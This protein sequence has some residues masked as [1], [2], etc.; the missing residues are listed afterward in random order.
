MKVGT[1]L[2]TAVTVATLAL[3]ASAQA[4]PA[5]PIPDVD[6]GSSAPESIGSPV[7]PDP[8]AAPDIPR[9][10]KMAPNG[11]S[12]L[13]NDGYMSDTYTWSGP[14][15]HG[16]S[17]RSSFLEGVCGS[18]TFDSRG[19]LVTVCVGLEGP[20]LVLADAR[21]LETLALR[22]LPPRQ[23]VA[24][25]PFQDFAG[26]GY[27]YLD[28]EDRVVAPTTTRHIMVIKVQGNDF[29]TQRDYDVSSLLAPND[30]IVSTL[31]DWSGR[32]WFVSGQGVVGSIDPHTGKPQLHKTGEVIAN[33]FSVDEDGGVYVVTDAALYRFD[34]DG[35]GAPK[36]TWREAYKNTGAQKPGQSSAGSGTTPTVMGRDLVSITDNADPI[37]IVVYRRAKTVKVARRICEEP[38][39]PKGK[40]STDQSLIG[41]HKSMIVENNYGYTG[42]LA[43]QGTPTTEPGLARVDVSSDRKAC[44]TIWKSDEIAPSVVPKLSLRSGLVYTYTNERDSSDPWYLTA[45]DF[46]TG[47]TVFKR[48]AGQSLGVNNNYAP[49][50]IAPDGSVYIGVLGG[51]VMLRNDRDPNA[52][53]PRAPRIALALKRAKDGAL[54]ASLKGEGNGLVASV[55]YRIAGKAAAK[56]SKTSPFRRTLRQATLRQGKR[57]T[58]SARVKLKDGRS[59][60]YK[61]RFRRR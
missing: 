42:P 35:D 33:S 32:I 21:T 54:R 14:L 1:T 50:T 13:H 29:Q 4:I 36:V 16:M 5:I 17:V 18:I 19:R 11:L 41:T 24:A 40:G 15:G 6:T 38:V 52:V 3:P 12:N 39:F 58:A 60:T 43:T 49:V 53:E 20:K 7:T 8:V 30:K 51:M 45:L 26:G 22:F 55:D 57:Y 25:N 44:K 2:V 59:F 37:N 10:P 23:S 28:D 46:R 61:A 9:H 31:P 34:A 48:L 47:K 56:R 27:F